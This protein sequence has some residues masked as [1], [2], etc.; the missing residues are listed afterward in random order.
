VIEADHFTD[1]APAPEVP[2]VRSVVRFAF[3]ISD[4]KLRGAKFAAPQTVILNERLA[5]SE[6]PKSAKPQQ[7]TLPLAF[8]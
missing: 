7:S 3:P 6:G 5:G 4:S 2:C 1:L 8:N